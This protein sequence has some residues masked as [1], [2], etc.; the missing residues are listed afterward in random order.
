MSLVEIVSNVAMASSNEIFNY[1]RDYYTL[2]LD[3]S[4][5]A[6]SKYLFTH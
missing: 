3:L 1:G 5:T 2:T 6:A 4:K